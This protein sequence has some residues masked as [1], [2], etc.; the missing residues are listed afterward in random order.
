MGA[1]LA[2]A[3]LTACTRQPTE[4]IVPYVRQPE[5]LVPGRPLFYATA[6]HAERRGQRRSG[7]KP[8]RP[9][10]QDRRQSGASR[11]RWARAMSSRRLRCCSLYDP[12]RS[13]A[14]TLEGEIRSWGDFLGSLREAA[15]AAEGQERRGHPH[16][17]RDGD[18]AHHGRPDQR[19]SR[20]S[21]RRP[22][23]ISGSRP[24][25]TARAP[26]PRMAFGQPVNT[27]YDLTQGQRDRLAGFRFPGVGRRQPALRAAVLR[28]APRAAAARPP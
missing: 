10:H 22:S 9:A 19:P 4:H 25:R 21:I 15:G 20:S 28:A 3:G 24:G 26:A 7:G 13:Q 14:L 2:L 27:Y 11:P 6:M 17:H 5:E 8:R 18:F 16:P 23:G 12:D 1:S